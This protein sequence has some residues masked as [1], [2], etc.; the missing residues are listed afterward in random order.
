MTPKEKDPVKELLTRSVSEVIEREHLVTALKMGKP[1]RVKL[2]IDPTSPNL[3]LGHTVVLRKLR[4]FQEAGHTAVLII[5]DFT[6]QIG[7]PS[8]RSEERKPLS[9][10]D[11]ETN[12]KEYL[13]QA[14]KVIDIKRTEVHHNSEWHRDEGLTAILELA[15]SATF[16]QVIKRAD[17]QKRI[18]AG[19]DITL[20]E[21]LYPLLQGY[22]SVKVKADVELGG[23]DQ[24]F[25]LLMGRR[26]QR[27]FKLPEQD[28]ITVPLIEGTDGVKKM[29]KSY[30][31]SIGIRETPTEM[32]G[33]LMTIPDGL[34]AKYFETLTD[35]SAPEV[36]NPRDAKLTLAHEIVKTYHSA[37]AADTEQENW[38][39]TF[40]KKEEPTDAPE[41]IIPKDILP[42]L[43]TVGLV[44]Y[45]IEGSSKSNALRL[46]N[47]G[48]VKLNG[49]KIMDP[50]EPMCGRIKTGDSLRVG[51][52]HFFRIEVK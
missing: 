27:H 46:V 8:G 48:A 49:E 31:N 19:N 6:A 44:V 40:S 1:L 24:I 21:I 47:A 39:R 17:F 22:D 12:E 26:V 13:A 9:E 29:S 45:V 11:I 4:A 3:H 18:E 15:R 16:Q 14:G 41:R 35:L 28:V 30:G 42:K 37:E 52:H 25:N 23:T 50:K 2:G 38:V 32:F 36:K 10:R 5:G 7:D 51:N 33:K 43:D 20:L 34:I